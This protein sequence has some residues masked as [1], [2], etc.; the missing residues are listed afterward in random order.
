M[1]YHS[2]F[3]DEINQFQTFESVQLLIHDFLN[4]VPN[5]V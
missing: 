3:E 5:P 2:A 4:G 1:D